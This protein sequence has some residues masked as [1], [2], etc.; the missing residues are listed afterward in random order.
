MRDNDAF[1]S[2]QAK[3]NIGHSTRHPVAAR[4]KKKA[5]APAGK[6]AKREAR[7]CIERRTD[8]SKP[9]PVNREFPPHPSGRDP[10]G[11]PTVGRPWHWLTLSGVRGAVSR[12]AD[13][14]AGR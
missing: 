4:K 5:Q 7:F 3:K 9:R 8:D 11:P 2:I 10:P 13:E 12:R 6:P 14:N 1:E